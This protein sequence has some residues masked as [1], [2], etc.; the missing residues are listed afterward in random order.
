MRGR[1]L[2]APEEVEVGVDF[3]VVVEVFNARPVID[4]IT[5][6]VVDAD[7][8]VIGGRR[9]TALFPDTHE[10][11]RL[12]V[13]LPESF[14]AGDHMLPIEICSSVDELDFT[15]IQVPVR[16]AP[17]PEPILSVRPHTKRSSKSAEY[18]LDITNHGNVPLSATLAATDADE[19]LSL[20]FTPTFLEIEPHEV[21]SSTLRAE[22]SRRWFGQE[23]HRSIE[24]RLHDRSEVITTQAT[25][26][27]RPLIPRG[28]LTAA[29]L[30][31]IVL[32]WA[33]V[34]LK[35]TDRIL[36]TDDYAM[37]PAAS[38]YGLLGAGVD[39]GL[40]TAP[41]EG[42]G[43]RGI[44]VTK[45]GGAVTG[46]VTGPAPA[47]VA[48]P[49]IRV[50]VYRQSKSGP[51]L[52][53]SA[54]TD[55]EGAFKV[56]PLMPGS[57]FVRASGDE[58]GNDGYPEVWM[59][60]QPAADT[61]EVIEV[62]AKTDAPVEGLVVSGDPGAIRGTVRVGAGAEALPMTVEIVDLID[63]TPGTF[64]QR[65]SAVTG[66]FS[67][68]DLPTPA[69]YRAR[70]VLEGFDP[71]A[72][73]VFVGGGEQV[74]LNPIQLNAGT[75]SISGTVIDD[76][77]AGMGAVT[78]TARSGDLTY[79]TA[80]PT[81]GAVGSFVLTQLPK[82][83]TY[84]L[85][86]E[87]EG[88]GTETQVVDLP[89]DGATGPV[90]VIMTSGVG[91]ISGRA[92]S[93]DEGTGGVTVT[94]SGNGVTSTATTITDVEGEQNV[95]SAGTGNAGR[96]SVTGLPVP[97]TYT[98]SFQ[99]DGL[100]LESVAVTLTN[101]QPLAQGI[102]VGL[103]TSAF[104]MS[105][106]VSVEGGGGT[107]GVTVELSDGTITRTTSSASNP[108]GSYRFDDIA[109]GSYVLRLSLPGYETGVVVV[110]VTGSTT[111]GP[112]VLKKAT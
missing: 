89:A 71:P 13:R 96:Y 84:L 77:G 103:H 26:V 14:P 99:R 70:V 52:T 104:S 63:G 79:T 27:H 95:C 102:D 108:A 5:A 88:Y 17:R 83:A 62:A 56:G 109:P 25:L 21:A 60:S 57:Y 50:D 97:G 23:L 66:E 73:D 11:M 86:F 67:V 110:D 46:T 28:V 92:C 8:T 112:V 4:R 37:V 15:H 40:S 49:R 18:R 101:A 30:V 105:G 12:T 82:P 19:A 76:T 98:V 1:L 7:V 20:T 68:A 35:G 94:V 74:E 22:G 2:G 32:A 58:F 61:D 91:T 10:E 6:T 47:F 39:G 87:K 100:T 3:D 51:V 34:F 43:T 78:V 42:G 53:G 72:V 85:V 81:G 36:G 90:S 64:V 38:Y 9:A 107:G 106:T 80:T 55:D 65:V 93:D 69:T 16:V 44:D 111:I 75:G 48:V 54:A 59:P 41:D 24:V 31:F 45:V 33:L 29:I